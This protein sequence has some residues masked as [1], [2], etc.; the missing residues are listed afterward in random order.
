[1]TPIVHRGHLSH[2]PK[3]D[4]EKVG[5]H[6][7]VFFLSY[8]DLLFFCAFVLLSS[9]PSLK[10]G[11]FKDVA[12]KDVS[13]RQKFLPFVLDGIKSTYWHLSAG[14]DIQLNSV[15]FDVVSLPTSSSLVNWH[16][17]KDTK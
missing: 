8:P 7:K 2:S 13:C 10:M 14:E 12:R 11:D 17:L 1:M 3:S 15:N 4:R 5:Q 6:L 9:F 16:S